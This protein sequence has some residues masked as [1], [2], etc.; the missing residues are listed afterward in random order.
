MGA[1]L[2]LITIFLA[3]EMLAYAKDY[4]HLIALVL[5]ST[6]A[7]LHLRQYCLLRLLD[8]WSFNLLREVYLVVKWLRKSRSQRSRSPLKVE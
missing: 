4:L 2:T 6:D 1:F 8:G 7:Q 3:A 5:V